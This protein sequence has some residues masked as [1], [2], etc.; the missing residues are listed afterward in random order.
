M[1]TKILTP[2]YEKKRE[3]EASIVSLK[4]QFEIAERNSKEASANATDLSDR[5]ARL[6]VEIEEMEKGAVEATKSA[7]GA[8]S[9]G[10]MG[11]KE[12]IST[13]EKGIQAIKALDARLEGTISKIAEA[14]KTEKEILEEINRENGKLEVF[15]RD[16]DIY[17]T[18]L[19]RKYKEL[20]LGELIL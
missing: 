2:L 10:I 12:V 1:Q 14:E 20:G 16:L 19:E 15:R 11:V 9:E 4:S 17:K 7:Q 3:L 13:F 6:G 8:V 18:R 5:I